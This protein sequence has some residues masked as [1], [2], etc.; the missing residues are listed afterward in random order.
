[1]PGMPR[2]LGEIGQWS[3]PF[4]FP[5]IPIHATLLPTGKILFWDR[6]DFPTGDGHPR[7]WDPLTGLFA[8]AAE[9]PPGHDLFCS[10]H[11]LLEDGRLFVAGGHYSDGIGQPFAATYEPFAGTWSLVPEMNAGRWYPTATLLADGSV[12]VMGGSDEAG[13]SNELPQIYRPASFG[14]VDLTSAERV[15][16][17]YPR[18]FQTPAG[19]ALVVSPDQNSSQLDVTA[20]GAW[21]SLASTGHG[22]RSYGS[23]VAYDTGK[24]LLAGGGETPT[25]TAQAIDLLQP[26]PTF[27]EV[28]P[29][30]AARRQHNLTLLPD[31]SVL[32]TGGTSAA[33]FNN[34]TGAVLAAELWNPITEEWTGLAAMAVPRIYHSIALLLPDG[35]VLSAGGGHPSDGEHGDPDH[36]NGEIYS[37]PYLFRGARPTIVQAPDS[38]G[39]G[40]LLPLTFG[41]EA[42]VATVTWLRL[43][44]ATHGFNMN[45][46]FLRLTAAT[47]AQGTSFVAPSDPRLAPPGHYL[48]FALTADG[49]PSL[50]RVVQLRGALFRDGFES[51][52]TA[53][54]SLALP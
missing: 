9:P 22:F 6:H 20:P 46:R 53:A 47:T 30:A 52:T 51:A 19:R 35:R 28:E 41:P 25:A 54:W 27:H 34:V 26:N 18:V 24:I 7:L 13:G 36:F 5:T 3:A 44:S 32:A 4:P 31:G 10:G 11:V 21:S 50:G 45:Q 1:M 16:P 40:D 29:M 17:F 43:G 2:P 14:W 8:K 37:P 42:P 39:L 33:G 12:L 23:A 48:M 38:V 15:L 49:V